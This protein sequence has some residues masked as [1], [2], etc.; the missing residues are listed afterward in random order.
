L[1]WAEQVGEALPDQATLILPGT[2]SKHLRIDR[3][4]ITGITTF[5]TGE[6]FELLCQHSVLRH[7][8]ATDAPRDPAA[9]RE[10]V[11]ASAE[12]RLTST[13]FQVRT[14]QVLAAQTGMANRSFLSGLL[15]GSELRA[16]GSGETPIVLAA[17]PALREAYSLAADDCGLASRWSAI[18]VDGLA[19]LGQRRL[20]KRLAPLTGN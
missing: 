7:S 4:A 10:G 17:G 16:L 18:E 3:G 5:M 9:F 20:W 2:H 12:D 11:V 6:L 8:V 15:I 1:G 19:E 14:R 13:L